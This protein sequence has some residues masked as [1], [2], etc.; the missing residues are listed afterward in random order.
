MFYRLAINDADSDG[1]P[2]TNHEEAQLNTDPVSIDTDL[3]G[4]PD[5]T[6]PTPLSS[7]TL[8]DPDGA[9]PPVGRTTNLLG[10]WDFESQ[11]APASPVVFPDKSGNDRHAI[12]SGTT[13]P[14]WP[15]FRVRLKS[16]VPECAT[17]PTA[18]SAWRPMKRHQARGTCL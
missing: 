18:K 15:N 14:P 11:N 6:D 3:D 9:N 13:G 8:A 5:N 10:F 12:G 17:K 7:A 1:D 16:Y 4:L 2:L